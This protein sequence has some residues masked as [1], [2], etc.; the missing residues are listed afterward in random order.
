MQ[1]YDNLDFLHNNS[2]LSFAAKGHGGSIFQQRRKLYCSWSAVCGR[3]HPRW[4]CDK[5]G[6]HLQ[7][8]SV[9]W[10][11]TV[12]TFKVLLGLLVMIVYFLKTTQS[13]FFRSTFWHIYRLDYD[14]WILLQNNAEGEEVS[15]G[16]N[17]PWL[18]SCWSWLMGTWSFIIL[19]A[20]FY[21]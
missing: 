20:Y 19:F 2:I 18:G 3:I 10:I 16:I 6:K 1:F 15:Q 11:E 5:S 14:I 4:I 12:F 17:W 21:I 7:I 13:L 9:S 8:C